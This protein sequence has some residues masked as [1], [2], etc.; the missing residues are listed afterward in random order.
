MKNTLLPIL[1]RMAVLSLLVTAGI[2]GQPST[3][4]G[5][6]FSYNEADWRQFVKPYV[7]G[8]SIKQETLCQTDKGRDVEMLRIGK[9][10][11]RMLVTARHHADDVIGNYV[12]KRLWIA[13]W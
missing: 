5:D 8:E 2:T 6:G 7:N 3:A 1:E 9:G 11:F 10:R 4:E 13:R 12:S